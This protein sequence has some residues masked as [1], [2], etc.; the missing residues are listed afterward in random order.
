MKSKRFSRLAKIVI[1]AVLV[2]CGA[3]FTS[4]G[5]QTENGKTSSWLLVNILSAY[6]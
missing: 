1:S 4:K 3:A 6:L 5:L 2:T